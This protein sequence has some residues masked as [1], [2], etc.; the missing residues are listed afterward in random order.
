MLLHLR[1]EP[2]LHCQGHLQDVAEI[3]GPY[4]ILPELP[5]DTA[6]LPRGEEGVR[7]NKQKEEILLKSHHWKS[8]ASDNN[9]KSVN[10]ESTICQAPHLM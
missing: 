3:L 10:G 4:K 5:P 6:Q 2:R 8:F 9:S 1:E 7:G